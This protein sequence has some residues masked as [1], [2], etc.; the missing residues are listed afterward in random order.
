MDMDCETCEVKPPKLMQLNYDAYNLWQHSQTQWMWTGGMEP[1]ISGLNYSAV[2]E[3]AK[4]MGI[5]MTP[6]LLSKL[7]ALEWNTIK[8]LRDKMA[9]KRK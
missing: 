6:C 7:Q 8:R 2:F 1:M 5:G 4:T 9:Q 3:V